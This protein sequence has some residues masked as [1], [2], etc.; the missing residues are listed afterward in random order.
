[1]AVW[2]V[3]KGGPG[4]AGPGRQESRRQVENTSWRGGS[5]SETER[6][7]LSGRLRNSPHVR[8]LIAEAYQLVYGHEPS[9]SELRYFTTAFLRTLGLAR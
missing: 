3:A 2:W 8:P 9:E 6:I 1:M 4:F 7:T 5:Q